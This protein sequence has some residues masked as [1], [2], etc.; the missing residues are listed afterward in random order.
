VEGVATLV[1][2]VSMLALVHAWG[3]Y[4]LVLVALDAGRRVR[5]R[6]AAL[7]SVP[8]GPVPRLPWRPKVSVL[9]AAHDEAACIG[10]KIENTLAFDYPADRL[11]LLVGSDGSTDGTDAIV[12]RFADRDVRLSRGPRAGK[13]GVLNRLARLAQGDVLLFTDANTHVA[14]D[15]LRRLVEALGDP[16][17][18]GASGQLR[19]VTPSGASAEEGLYWRLENLLKSYESEA[20]A[21]MGANGGLYALKADAWRPLPEGTVVDDLVVSMRVLLEGRRLVWVPAALAVEETSPGPVERRR[22]V[23]IAAGN[24]QALPLLA[25][26]LFGRGLVSFAFWSH[27][28]LRWTGPLWMGLLLAASPWMAGGRALLVLQFVG[29]L[30]ALLPACWVARLGAPM[31]AWCTFASMNGAFVLGFIRHLRGR[32]TAVWQRTERSHAAA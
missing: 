28:L 18:G 29:Y 13:A 14:P 31:R 4:L 2:G 3:G 22:R 1:F 19:L 16:S 23:R 30:L 5:A 21:L 12:G 24:F 9:V 25:P 7:T 27:K 6:W 11:E 32:Q 15:A 26:L 10:A 8:T 17:V 20:G